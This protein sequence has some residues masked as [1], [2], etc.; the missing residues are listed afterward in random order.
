VVI[1][2]S[3]FEGA[4]VMLTWVGRLPSNFHFMFTTEVTYGCALELAKLVRM[5][6][7][8]VGNPQ[9]WSAVAPNPVQ[10]SSSLLFD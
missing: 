5:K 10:R 2:A 6:Y 3:R 4:V 9:H 7:F 8:Y 1:L